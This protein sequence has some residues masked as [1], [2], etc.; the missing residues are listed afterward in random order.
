MRGTNVRRAGRGGWAWVVHLQA[1]GGS[2]DR[3][4]AR[5]ELISVE[6]LEEFFAAEDTIPFVLVLKSEEG[7]E[8]E[9]EHDREMRAIISSSASFL[10]GL[11]T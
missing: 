8:D 11:A 4:V 2:S 3:D 10:S 5:Y 9:D 7:S 6:L 1:S